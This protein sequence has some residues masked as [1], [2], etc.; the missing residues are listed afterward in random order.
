VD[1]SYVV[2]GLTGAMYALCYRVTPSDSRVPPA[3][4]IS[5]TVRVQPPH[6][7]EVDLL[8]GRAPDVGLSEWDDTGDRRFG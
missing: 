3:G 7:A 8:F 4:A 1:G 6:P 5:G 2:T